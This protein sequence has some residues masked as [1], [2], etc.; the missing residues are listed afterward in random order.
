MIEKFDEDAFYR[1][2]GWPTEDYSLCQYVF[3][4]VCEE[5]TSDYDQFA[6]ISNCVYPYLR[7]TKKRGNRHFPCGGA[8]S[9]ATDGWFASKS[10]QERDE[11]CPKIA[12]GYVSVFLYNLKYDETQ[13]DYV[14]LKSQDVLKKTFYEEYLNAYKQCHNGLKFSNITDEQKEL[15]FIEEHLRIIISLWEKSKPLERYPVLYQY[16]IQAEKEYESF[17]IKRKLSLEMKTKRNNYFSTEIS[18]AFDKP[19][20]KVYFLNDTVAQDAKLVVEALN[21]VRKVNITESKSQSHPGRT[22]TVY[23]KPMVLAESCDKEV[24]NALKKFFLGFGHKPS[25]IT[26]A[27]FD[28]IANQIVGD[29]DKARVSILVAVAWFTKQKIADKLIEKYKEGLDVKIVYFDDHINSKFGVDVD[30]IPVKAV[31]GSR[32]GKMHNK[33]CVID[34]QKVITGSYNWSENA[35][36]KNDENAAVIYDYDRASDYSVEFRRLFDSPTKG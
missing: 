30:G 5:G 25:V 27:Y 10:E 2:D 24:Q 6:L 1:D 9:P 17:L 19:Y 13:K 18:S 35:E 16:S 20:I 31:K 4:V 26:D 23:P 11:L 22:L 34:N 7:L 28:N 15:D 12:W 8:V 32:G 21:V 3:P 29:L 33:F 14:L 36:N